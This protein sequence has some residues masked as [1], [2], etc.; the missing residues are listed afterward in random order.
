MLA[1]LTMYSVPIFSMFQNIRSKFIVKQRELLCLCTI[2]KGAL[3][4]ASHFCARMFV[5]KQ[6]KKTQLPFEWVKNQDV[7]QGQ[8]YSTIVLDIFLKNRF[9]LGSKHIGGMRYT[10]QEGGRGFIESIILWN[11]EWRHK[12][13]G[14]ALM[15]RAL[16]E[17]DEAKVKTVE[18]SVGAW[19]HAVIALNKKFGFAFKE[20]DINA[21]QIQQR[22]LSVQDSL[23]K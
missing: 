12:G 13:F 11:K 4:K 7:F 3:C 2:K 17:M 20:G 15:Q 10:Y 21:G 22:V 6:E 9:F 14:S 1:F 16:G 5:E 8:E 23:S 19:N 18:G